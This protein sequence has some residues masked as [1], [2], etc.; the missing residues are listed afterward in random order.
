MIR[1]HTLILFF[2]QSGMHMFGH[3]RL[4]VPQG[5]EHIS[6]DPTLQILKYDEISFRKMY[7]MTLFS[8]ID[9]TLSLAAPL[10][11]INYLRRAGGLRV[12]YLGL[13]FFVNSKGRWN[14]L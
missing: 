3:R 11:P 14:F 5:G 12:N 8:K 7:D 10:A 1:I 6:S 9:I 2:W 4:C 13:T